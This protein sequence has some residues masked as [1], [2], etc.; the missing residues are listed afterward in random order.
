MGEVLPESVC[1]HLLTAVDS[2]THVQVR[3]VLA[4]TTSRLKNGL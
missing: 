2:V 4:N 1:S 3:N